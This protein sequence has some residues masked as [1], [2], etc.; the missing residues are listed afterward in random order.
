L[1]GFLA[2]DSQR[3]ISFAIQILRFVPLTQ[4]RISPSSVSG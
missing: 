1:G 3:Q 2:A 4:F